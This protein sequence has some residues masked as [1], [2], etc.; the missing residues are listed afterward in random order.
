MGKK[1]EITFIPKAAKEYRKIDG[2]VKKL[3]DVALKKMIDRADDL[4]EELVNKSGT[5]LHGCRKIKFRNAGIR[6]VYRIIGDRAE[7]VEIIAIG[8]REDSEV[9]ELAHKRLQELSSSEK[10]K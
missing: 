7:I 1:F 8:K 3:V 6:I 9:Y 5:K 2:S 4:G 10:K